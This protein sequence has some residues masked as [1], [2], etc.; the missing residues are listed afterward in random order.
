M[1]QSQAMKYRFLLL[2]LHHTKVLMHRWR[3]VPLNIILEILDDLHNH[4]LGAG[5]ERILLKRED[6]ELVDAMVNRLRSPAPFVREVACR[7]L[8]R[9][10]GGKIIRLLLAALADQSMMV[11]RAA[12]FAL[13][14]ISDPSSVPQLLERYMA[15]ANDDINVRAA[16]ECALDTMGA[17]YTKH[18]D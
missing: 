6:P 16:L 3:D 10:G 11:R 9:K 7:V 18:P 4:R 5:V 13:A 1:T 14:D 15:S 8:G 2:Y 17:D 12:G